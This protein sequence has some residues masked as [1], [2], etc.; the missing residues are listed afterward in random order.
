[1]YDFYG[2]KGK[3]LYVFNKVTKE[4]KS[5]DDFG[6][7]VTGRGN[8]MNAT[9]INPASIVSILNGGTVDPTK[10]EIFLDNRICRFNG[11]IRSVAKKLRGTGYI[12]TMNFIRHKELSGEPMQVIFVYKEGA[13]TEEILNS[14]LGLDKDLWQDV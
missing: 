12:G 9:S 4:C 5:F 14:T 1:M 11:E 8:I 7:E 10:L 2:F 6:S 13:I 3:T